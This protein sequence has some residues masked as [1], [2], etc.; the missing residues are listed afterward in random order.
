MK[1]SLFLPLFSLISA[2]A[3]RADEPK[4]GASDVDIKRW[5]GQLGSERFEDREQATQRLSKLGKDALPSLREAIKSPDAEVRRR[6]QELV[7]EIQPPAVRSM[8][9]HPEQVIPAAKSYL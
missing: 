8:G 6:A 4:S 3:V 7:E 5:I 1:L 2:L 9:P